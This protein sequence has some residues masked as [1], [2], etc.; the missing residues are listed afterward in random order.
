M[1]TI[2]RYHDN[3]KV[4]LI[5]DDNCCKRCKHFVGIKETNCEI[6]FCLR[7]PPAVSPRDGK[8][9]SQLATTFSGWYCGEFTRDAD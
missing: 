4:A 2:S 3:V 8:D 7:Y 1:K 6:G 9:G 5:G